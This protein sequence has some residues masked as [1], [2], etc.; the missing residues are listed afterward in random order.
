LDKLDRAILRRLQQDSR[1]TTEELGSQI[2]LSAT[3]CQRRIKKLRQ[4]KIIRKEI[5]VLD[6]VS[7]G[8]HVSVI[9]SL[10]LERGGASAIDA[11]REKMRA[12]EAVQQ[13]Y[14]MAG[15]I[16][17]F[18]LITAANLLEYE[19]LTRE[20]FLNDP[21][22]SKFHSHVVMENLKVGLAIPLA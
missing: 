10:T 14:Y 2:G 6:G 3:A 5:A 8:G 4:R 19:K 18:L 13:C 21:N 17:F 11:F 9:V 7:A 12:T 20:L 22:V 16:D 1:I 15:G